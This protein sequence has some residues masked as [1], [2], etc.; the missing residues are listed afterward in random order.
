M[1]QILEVTQEIIDISKRKDTQKCPIANTIIKNECHNPDDVYVEKTFT[2]IEDWSY[3]HTEAIKD[4]I[5]AYDNDHEIKPFTIEIWTSD[6][7]NDS[8]ISTPDKPEDI[9]ENYPQ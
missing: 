2:L 3:Q 5:Y 4:I 6:S 8:F 1:P 7:Y 9:I